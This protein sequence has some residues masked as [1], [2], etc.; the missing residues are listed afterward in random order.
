MHPWAGLTRIAALMLPV[1]LPLA[2][3]VAADAQPPELRMAVQSA[4]V[5]DPHLLF[6][7]PNMAASRH[8]YDS[9][10]GKDEDAHWTP[11]LAASWRQVDATT[12]EFKLR[13]DVLFSDG[14]K[15][16][17]EDVLA[18]MARIPAIPN[19]P[20][21]YTSNIRTIVATQ[22][23]DPGTVRFTTDR[24][25]PLLPGQFTNVFILPKSVVNARPE[26]FSSGRAA[27]GTGPFRVTSFRY[28]EAME[29]ERN[30]N[31]WGKPAA[32]AK[33][34]TRVIGNDAAREAALLAGD[35]DLIENVPP[36]DVTRL[37]ATAGIGVF[38]RA[39]DRVL[40][41]LP[42]VGADTLALLTDRDGKP[43]PVNPLRDLR[44]RQAMSLAIDRRALVDRALSGQGTASMQ[45]VPDGF[46]GWDPAVTVP[47]A[48]PASARRKLAEAG[49]PDGFGLTIA[50]SNDRYVDDGRVCQAVAQMLSR[51][52]FTVQV[53]AMPGSLFFPRSRA[54]RN[55]FPLILYGLS[56]SSLRDGAY[57]LQVVAHG[58]D[59]KRGLGDGNRGSFTDP[60]LDA[61]IDDATSRSDDG[62]EAA[63]R[64]ALGETV[65]RL[66]II[67]MYAEPTIAAA[68]GGIVYHPRID[69]QMVAT[70]AI[71][72]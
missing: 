69:Q 31:Y 44:V 18:T 63:I 22:A 3:A 61:L 10:V 20:G 36:E 70:G 11:T 49:Y 9:F 47:P 27:I 48:D 54:E 30:P 71:P 21:P 58:I 51:G 35:V 68:R 26:E 56:L 12:W 53:N 62:R 41:L 38:S 57:I 34:H 55:P 4:F 1:L 66:G 52:G 46:G 17:A 37:R 14:E 23:I 39:S 43:L 64:H 65:A 13:P 25:N 16:T 72:P 60:A 6:I 8:L 28:G 40:F 15:F 67:P 7:G 2:P 19:N 50:C 5:V 45:L 32:W 59:D 42:T 24:P 33:V 29:L